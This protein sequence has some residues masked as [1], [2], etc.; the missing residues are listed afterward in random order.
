LEKGGRS[1]EEWYSIRDV[2]KIVNQGKEGRFSDDV[3]RAVL[4]GSTNVR[5][6]SGFIGV[7][8]S[9][10]GM[11]HHIR[12][13]K[14]SKYYLKNSLEE[15]KFFLKYFELEGPDAERIRDLLVGEFPDLESCIRVVTELGPKS[16]AKHRR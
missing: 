10:D 6:R 14:L 11:K 13:A 8:G 5:G 16:A 1:E 2:R 15:L 12:C 3:I 7:R 9:Y 4:L